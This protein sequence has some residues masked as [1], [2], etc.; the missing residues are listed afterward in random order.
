MDEKGDPVTIKTFPQKTFDTKGF[1]LIEIIVVIAIVAVVA[2]MS[3][4]S[5]N[6]TGN[7]MKRSVRELSAISQK[8]YHLARL[9]Q[10]TYRIV[11]DFGERDQEHR[12]WVESSTSVNTIAKEEPEL[13][14]NEDPPVSPF[15]TDTKVLKKPKTLPSPLIFSDIELGSRDATVKSGVAYIHYLPQ[16]LVEEAVIH[17]T[18]SKNISWTIAIHPLTGETNL[19]TKRVELKE[20][21]QD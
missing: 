12:Y 2:G 17:L 10:K 15:S 20:L 5:I 7:Q 8:L 21:R 14:A 16:G 3:L 9:N 11:L 6:T 19:Y 13:K 4:S 18:D 1:T